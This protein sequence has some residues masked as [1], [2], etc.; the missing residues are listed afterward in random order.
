MLYKQQILLAVR[1][2]NTLIV[3]EHFAKLIKGV[4]QLLKYQ[5]NI[6]PI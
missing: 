1:N 3:N 2:N 5:E 4:F 6:S